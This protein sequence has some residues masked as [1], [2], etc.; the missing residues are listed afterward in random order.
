M[1]HH[2]TR[3][4]NG[5]STRGMEST[6]FSASFPGRRRRCP[7]RFRRLLRKAPGSRLPHGKEGRCPARPVTS[8]V[9]SATAKGAGGCETGHPISRQKFRTQKFCRNCFD[10]TAPHHKKSDRRPLSLN[11]GVT[12][13]FGR[14]LGAE[15]HIHPF[16]SLAFACVPV[17]TRNRPPFDPRTECPTFLHTHAVASSSTVV[18]NGRGSTL[19]LGSRVQRDPHSKSTSA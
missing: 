15:V 11:Q 3:A 17:K 12:Y 14:W 9:P 1:D 2:R 5:R 16:H 8:C 7:P 10:G 19:R 18:E 13:E 4:P 6:F